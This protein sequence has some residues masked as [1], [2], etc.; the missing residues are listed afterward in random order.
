MNSEIK[1][2]GAGAIQLFFFLPGTYPVSHSPI[3]NLMSN[4]SNL[5]SPV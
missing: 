1:K 3:S 2:T 5:T 4:V